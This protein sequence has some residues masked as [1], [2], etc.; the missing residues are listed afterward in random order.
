[1]FLLVFIVYEFPSFNFSGY[2]RIHSGANPSKFV[3][4]P[5]I[6]ALL[7][8]L[9]PRVINTVAF[10]GRRKTSE[11]QERLNRGKNFVGP[12]FVAAYLRSQS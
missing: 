11:T 7:I 3:S 1:M 2:F 12:A 4:S 5:S 10:E 8:L 9:F 6:P